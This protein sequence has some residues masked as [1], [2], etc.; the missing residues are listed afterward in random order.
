MI[1][2]QRYLNGL[3]T[4]VQ[5]HLKGYYKGNSVSATIVHVSCIIEVTKRCVYIRKVIYFGAHLVDVECKKA[6]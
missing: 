5:D 1:I 2:M 3:P 6:A 4:A